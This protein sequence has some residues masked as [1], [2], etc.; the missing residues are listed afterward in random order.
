[1]PRRKKFSVSIPEFTSYRA[2]NPFVAIY[3][4]TSFWGDPPHFPSLLRVLLNFQ[5]PFGS[6]PQSRS[7]FSGFYQLDTAPFKTTPTTTTKDTAY[8]QLA[9]L[10]IVSQFQRCQKS[11]S[12]EQL[13]YKA[14]MT[15]IICMSLLESVLFLDK[16]ETHFFVNHYQAGEFS[17]IRNALH[18]SPLRYILDTMSRHQIYKK[19]TTSLRDNVTTLDTKRLS[20]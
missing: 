2:C 17:S 15:S 11:N 8:N 7:G 5:P 1:M 10:E 20:K 19:K 18:R 6:S 13:L 14:S 9:W 4:L 16:N 12:I 3:M